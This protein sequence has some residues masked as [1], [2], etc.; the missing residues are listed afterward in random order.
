MAQRISR[1]KQSIKASRVPFGMPDAE[2]RAQRL[3]SVLHVLYLIFNEGY[4]TS[5]GASLHRTDLSNEAIRLTRAVRT[6][7][8]D[9]A[10]GRRAAGADAAHRRA[11][12]RAHR[13][14]R[15]ADSARRAGPNAVGSR[16][17][18]PKASRW[19]ARRLSSGSVGEYQLQAAIAAVAR[20]GAARRG[21]RLAA[22]PRAVRRAAADV[23]QSRWWRSITRS[24]PRWSTGPRAGT[25]AARIARQRRAPR[26]ESSTDRRAR[27]PVGACR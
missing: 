18:S 27:A 25:G 17:R 19:S 12:R 14:G 23:R 4:T 3:S 21:H 1:A 2:E 6:L 8:P 24:R 5:S 10:R 13:T 20:R 26:R 11:P 7:L 15:R 22:D 16:R 9:D